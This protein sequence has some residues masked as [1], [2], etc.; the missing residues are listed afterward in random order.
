MHNTR[1]WLA[2]LLFL[3]A[4]T[5]SGQNFLTP[6][7]YFEQVSQKFSTIEDYQANITINL[8]EGE[9]VMV[10]SVMYKSPNKLRIDFTEPREQV[11]AM[12]GQK[13]I[14]YIPTYSYALEQT[15]VRRSDASV[16]LMASSQELS[17][18]KDNYSVAYLIGPD[19]VPLSY[20]PGSEG[21]SEEDEGPKVD[22]ESEEMV[23]KLKFQSRSSAE[24]F[25][26]LEI[27]FAESGFIRRVTGRSIGKQL[28]LD[29]TDV[30]INENIPDAKFEYKAPANANVFNDFLFEVVD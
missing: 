6:A 14:V 7:R 19:A 26:R 23:M 10:G 4:L 16:A 5:L 13:L 22:S 8:N 1:L 17:Y 24:G 15:L 9:L 30:R 27:A 25:R 20:E 2:L 12:D 11:L 3:A 21:K 29:F 28:T 18:L